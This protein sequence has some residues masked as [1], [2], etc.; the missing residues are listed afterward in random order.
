[1]QYTSTYNIQAVSVNQVN[2]QQNSVAKFPDWLTH[3]YLPT[4]TQNIR[5]HRLVWTY[6]ENGR[7]SNSQKSIISEFGINKTK[8]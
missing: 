5:L 1:L 8:R 6:T 2:F 4:I 3:L 7:K